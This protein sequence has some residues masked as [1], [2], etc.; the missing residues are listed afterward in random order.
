MIV[1]LKAWDAHDWGSEAW[2]NGQVNGVRTT[3][4]FPCAAAVVT[5]PGVDNT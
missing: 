5:L 3:Q 4:S 1:Q 2:L